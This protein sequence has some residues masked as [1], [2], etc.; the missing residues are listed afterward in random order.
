MES[1]VNPRE[2]LY[3]NSIFVLIKPFYYITSIEPL[4]YFESFVY[5]HGYDR[6]RQTLK[7]SWTRLVNVMV[8]RVRLQV[9]KSKNLVL[10]KKYG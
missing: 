10:L 3:F 4:I 7:S 1:Q 9:T 6:L 2:Y 8:L 5:R